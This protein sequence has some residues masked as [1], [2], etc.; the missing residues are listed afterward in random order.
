MIH[1]AGVWGNG[2][3]NPSYSPFSCFLTKRQSYKP[4]GDLFG[5]FSSALFV[6]YNSQFYEAEQHA[7]TLIK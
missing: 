1:S 5:F 3:Q 4:N 7:C 6:V 2:T